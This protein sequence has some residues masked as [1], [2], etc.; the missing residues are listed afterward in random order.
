MVNPIKY[1]NG[2]YW[3]CEKKTKTSSMHS[4]HH[5]DKEFLHVTRL[6]WKLNYCL[7]DTWCS[8]KLGS[9]SYSVSFLHLPSLK[10]SCTQPHFLVKW[11][12]YLWDQALKEPEMLKYIISNFLLHQASFQSSSLKQFWGLFMFI[13]WVRV[14]TWYK[15]IWPMFSEDSKIWLHLPCSLWKFLPDSRKWLSV[16]LNS[17]FCCHIF[18]FLCTF[19]DNLTETWKKLK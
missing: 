19:S 14:L 15:K 18:I 7:R 9:A 4:Y 17:I 1:Y 3:I 11:K 10:S 13:D 5:L 6:C 8:C 16:S 12:W 2:S